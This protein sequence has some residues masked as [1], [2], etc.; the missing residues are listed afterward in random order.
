[1]LSLLSIDAFT[2]SLNQFAFKRNIV[3]MPG[4]LKADDN[5]YVVHAN[6]KHYK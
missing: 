2:I 6:I 4:L 1:M 5:Q 3:L